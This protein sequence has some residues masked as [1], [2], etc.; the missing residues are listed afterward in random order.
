MSAFVTSDDDTPIL[1]LVWNDAPRS[2]DG[3]LH[4][5][6]GFCRATGNSFS[7]C[8]IVE[9]THDDEAEILGADGSV[10]PGTP[11]S[12]WESS[13]I[14]FSTIRNIVG[15]VKA[16]RSLMTVD[17]WQAIFRE[18][19]HLDLGESRGARSRTFSV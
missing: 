17:S 10:E 18:E 12:S 8:W 5:S 6:F 15:K 11:V 13:K 19:Q 9:D 16:D 14:S 1:A 4:A 2:S 7:N 3:R